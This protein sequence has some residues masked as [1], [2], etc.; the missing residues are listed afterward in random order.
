VADA[1]HRCQAIVRASAVLGTL[2]VADRDALVE[3]VGRI[4]AYVSQLETTPTS[5]PL[6]AVR[7]ANACGMLQVAMLGQ[8]AMLD[9]LRAEDWAAEDV[10][11]PVLELSRLLRASEVRAAILRDQPDVVVIDVDID[12]A[13]ECVQRLMADESTESIPIVVMGTWQ[14]TADSAPYV[15]LGV[16]R[17]LAKPTSPGELRRALL[18]VAPGWMR[19]PFEPIGET[20][21][22][23]LG[24]RLSNELQR[25]LCDA[26][27]DRS[28]GRTLDLGD[29][30]EVLT[31]LWD[32][33]ARIRQLVT[34]RAV[35]FASILPIPRAR[36]RTLHGS[37]APH[38]RAPIA[39]P[40]SGKF[41]ASI[42][43]P[44][45]RATPSWW[46]TTTRR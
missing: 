23:R 4:E 17:C 35:P 24:A 5:G 42:R 9:A 33:I 1:L 44:A 10:R 32:A 2:D 34:A 46:P 39:P 3:S 31:A 40:P 13:A 6:P 19:S 26:A 41:G 18:S 20:T 37:A 38:G 15:A 28:R 45:S 7:R 12:G 8:G 14:S 25:G 22:D 29:G 36:C 16:A 30:N 11:S 21:L 43:P 27:G